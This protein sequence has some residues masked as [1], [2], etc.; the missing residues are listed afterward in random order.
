MSIK[1]VGVIGSGLM[2]TG[3]AQACATAG[4]QVIVR[5]IDPAA[6]KRCM[7]AV[8][9]SLTRL[10]G[11]QKLTEAQ[12][13]AA[14]AA[15]RTTTEL[16]DLSGAD[17]IIEAATENLALKQKILKEIEVDRVAVLHHRDQHLVGLDHQAR[18]RPWRSPAASSACIS[19]IRCR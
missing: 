6:L 7:D 12:M 1:I 18:R 3:I 5:D 11:K 19:S 16:K 17:F 10:V 9:S 15:I 4:L 13:A 8:S 2:G 14:L